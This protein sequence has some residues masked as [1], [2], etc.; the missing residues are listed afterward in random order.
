MLALINPQRSFASFSRKPYPI[1]DSYSFGHHL[2][3]YGYYPSWLPL[4]CYMSHGV[5]PGVSVAP[6]EIESDACVHFTFSENR[7]SELRK[8]LTKP[9]YCVI[10]PFVWYR[11][12]HNIVPLADAKGV[13]VYY[14]HS[15]GDVKICDP[16]DAYIS[17]LKKL[18]NKYEVVAVCLHLCD[19]N[20]GVYKAFMDNDFP[21]YTAGYNMDYR[22]A[23]R[24]YDIIKHFKYAASNA[25]GS[26]TMY[27]VEMGIPF[28]LYGKEPKLYNEGDKNLPIGSYDPWIENEY[29]AA[30]A[31]FSEE[32]DKITEEQ[33]NYVEA[34][35][36][37]NN[38]ISRVEAAKI[39]YGAY[40]K[41]G[42]IL[43]DFIKAPNRYCKFFI[44]KM[45][46]LL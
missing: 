36:C 10:S 35:L 15:T 32:V 19:V 12:K 7:I 17:D 30:R 21:V 46:G 16:L 1:T 8:V 29:K 2:R 9:C 23:Q 34:Q 27:S 37:V 45:K 11:R 18:R 13:I 42:S 6:H 5:G 26:Y 31:L 33:K 28:F 14:S 24:W 22:Y 20:K 4:Y 3:D 41:R 40:W 43:R 38:S 44:R 39:L 25:I